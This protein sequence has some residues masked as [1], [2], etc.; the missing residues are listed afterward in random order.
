MVSLID[1]ATKLKLSPTLASNEM[2]LQRRAEGK[3][4]LHMGFG[5]A[6]FPVAPR[7]KEA[8]KNAAHRKDYLPTSGLRELRAAVLEYYAQKTGLNPDDFDVIIAP[9]SKLV[10]YALQMAIA[11]DLLMCVPSWVSYGPQAIM[12]KTN[13]I[14]VPMDLGGGAYYLDPSMLRARI[15]S[16][17]DQGLSPRKIILNYPNNPTG[18]TMSEDNL[19]D[20]AQVCEEEDIFIISDEI[21]GAI[22]FDKTYRSIVNMAPARTAISSGLSKNM[23]L[24]GWRLGIGIIPKA[25]PGLFDLLCNIASET[26]SCVPA[27]IQQ[28]VIECFENNEDI[29]GYIAD[30]AE[31]HCFVNTYIAERLR[32][33][34][35]MAPPPQGAFYNYPNFAP[36]KD[37]LARKGVTTSQE[38]AAYLLEHYGV[39]GL[40]GSAFGEDD[41]VLTLR[42]A[43]CDYDGAAALGAY[44][45]GETLDDAFMRRY[46]PNIIAEGDVFNTITRDLGL[47]E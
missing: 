26:W 10:L 39:V 6:P 18:L 23:S 25:V 14:K 15:K 20:I 37:A 32:Q 9:G 12:V 47:A 3:R 22:S 43:G 2:V 17:R 38:L 27:P 19:R 31:I 34:G 44:Q 40:P 11:G 7:L 5:E 1:T 42:L 30:C 8:L 35:L 4:V 41:D 28:A 33:A 16:A 13:V 36:F 24:G 46:M 45:A 21:Y 29:E